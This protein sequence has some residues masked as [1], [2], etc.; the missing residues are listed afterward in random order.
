MGG[1]PDHP[2]ETGRKVNVWPKD[3]HEG[4]D[5]VGPDSPSSRPLDPSRGHAYV[6]C[7]YRT[8]LSPRTRTSQ[9]S[10]RLG[11]S[12]PTPGTSQ[13]RSSRPPLSVLP[14]SR[15]SRL[16]LSFPGVTRGTRTEGSSV[17]DV[18]G[19]CLPLSLCPTDSRVGPVHRPFPRDRLGTLGSKVRGVGLRERK[20]ERETSWGAG[21]CLVPGPGLCSEVGRKASLRARRRPPISPGST[22]AVRRA[23][24]PLCR[25][26]VC[27]SR[28]VRPL[29]FHPKTAAGCC[30]GRAP[31]GYRSFCFPRTGSSPG[32]PPEPRQDEGSLTRTGGFLVRVG[33]GSGEW[34]FGL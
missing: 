11:L 29:T 31:E 17:K 6:P 33:G 32:T 21:R 3:R 23:V 24:S 8:P 10:S 19:L 34:G 12:Q 25:N 20:E 14:G 13:P 15:S 18:R 9:W 16:P 26:L 22:G 28:A 7:V 27:V 1:A 30:R 5:P 2:S 4:R